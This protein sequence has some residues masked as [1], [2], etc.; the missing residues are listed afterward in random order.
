MELLVVIVIAAILMAIGIPNFGRLIQHNSMR[1]TALQVYSFTQLA[2]SEA[3][4]KNSDVVICA[5]YTGA[6]CDSNNLSDGLIF[7]ADSNHNNQMDGSEEVRQVLV[8]VFS[9]IND[10]LI[11]IVGD[12]KITFSSNGRVLKKAT[13]EFENKLFK[14]Q[15]FIERSGRVYLGDLIQKP[16]T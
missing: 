3:I 11:V 15:M 16:A 2:R 14:K 10:K 12:P 8:P 4:A 6:A 9:N 1:S 5:S 13:L 7:F